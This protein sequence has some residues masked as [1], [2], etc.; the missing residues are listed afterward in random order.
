M[1]HDPG[2]KAFAAFRETVFDDFVLASWLRV[3]LE[4]EAYCKRVVELG[5]DRGFIFEVD[6]V[7]AA[8]RD[9]ERAWLM[10]GC[11]VA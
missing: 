1:A 10:Q 4:R 7:R 3:P 5:A 6:D 8:L 11:E 9:G 2:A